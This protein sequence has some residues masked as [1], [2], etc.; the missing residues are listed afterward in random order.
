MKIFNLFNR[1]KELK[2]ATWKD[3]TLEMFYKLR[4]ILACPDEFT[5]AN[6]IELIYKVDVTNLPITETSK[7]DISFLE[8]ELPIKNVKLKDKYVLNGR[9][10]SSNINLT[11]VTTA[12]F[13][14]FT[15]YSKEKEVRYEKLLSVFMVPEGHR[16]NDGY[17]L[18][19]VQDD[20]LQMPIADVKSLAFFMIE[21][22]QAFALIFQHYLT[23]EASKMPKEL[24]KITKDAAQT[25][26]NLASF[27]L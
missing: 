5:I 2:T 4:D 17:D 12:Q 19:E 27:Q 22:F 7:Y 18:M 21:Q 24:Q 1:K 15:N 25:I 13:I 14:D 23:E 26:T 6:I 8:K 10:Y 16:Y 20:I 3:I 9:K 11:E